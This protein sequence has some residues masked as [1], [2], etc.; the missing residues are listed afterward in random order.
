VPA[1]ADSDDH[2]REAPV[3]R[4]RSLVEPAG[5]GDE[6]ALKELILLLQPLVLRYCRARLGRG[7]RTYAD[8]DD[9]AQEVML[10]V[11]TALP[12][13]N[14]ELDRFLGFVYGI[15]AHKVA[16]TH[17][18]RGR[19][20]PHPGG[21]LA[22]VLWSLPDP[23]SGPAERAEQDDTR[24]RMSRLLDTLSPQS[25]DILILRVIVGLSARDTAQ[26]VGLAS[27]GAVRVAQHRAL[28]R[29]RQTIT[30]GRR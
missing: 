28:N 9:V 14:Y 13:Y 17:R 2:P 23:D 29:L 20:A 19:D 10:A 21:D 1:A 22:D 3:D 4:L 24:R 6:L 25:R 7:G 16:D 30:A 12:R 18:R 5:R 11:L 15:A 8:A 27:A 26:A